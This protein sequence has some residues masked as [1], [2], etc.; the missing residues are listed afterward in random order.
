MAKNRSHTNGGAL[1]STYGTEQ[2]GISAEVAIA[3]LTDVAIDSAYRSRGRAELIRHMTPLI[4][5]E[6]GNIPKPIKHIAEDQNPIDFLLEGGKTLSVKSNM[7]AAGMVAPQNIGQPT[8]STF[9]SRMPHLVPAGL[10]ISSLS[11]AESASMFKQVALNN[12]SVLLAE[13]WRNLFDCDYLIYICNVLDRN[14]NLTN[15]PTVSLYEK[16]HSPL[17]DPRRISFTKDLNNWNESCTV[18]YASFS[19]GEFQIH[20][21]RNCFKFR[22]NL[23]GLI[24]AGLL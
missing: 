3:D 20:N 16:S 24:Q 23:K 15:S 11:Y 1:L 6:L 12:A 17:W 2:V 19:I 13:Y 9:W 8:S 5:R 21:N 7:R 18:K 14:D 4:A 10:D 22:F